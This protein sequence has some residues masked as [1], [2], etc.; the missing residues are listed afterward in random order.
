MVGI[1]PGGPAHRTIAAVEAITASDLVV[2][3]TPYVESIADLIEGKETYV[4]AMRQE[5]KRVRV[6]VE[7]ASKGQ[8]VALVS[9]GDPGIYGMAGLAIELAAAEGIDVDIE[10]IAGVTAANAAAAAVGAPLMLDF[11]TISL[12]DLLV[13]WEVIAK[14]IDAVASADMV[15]VLYNPRSKKRQTQ[16]TETLLTFKKYRADDTPVAVVTAAGTDDESVTL[17]T[18]AGIDETTVGMRSVVIIGNSQTQMIGSRMVTSRG[19][20]L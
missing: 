10:V 4:S 12:S 19:Y 13:S 3:Y 6:A 17:T 5:I 18:L 2:G 16:L 9:S 11:A 15:T 8:T 7:A 20:E 1:G 14:R